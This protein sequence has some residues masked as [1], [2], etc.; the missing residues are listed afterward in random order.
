MLTAN[1]PEH[2]INSYIDNIRTLSENIIFICTKQKQASEVGFYY[3]VRYS[4]LFQRKT[5][6]RVVVSTEHKG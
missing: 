3:D 6:V 2:L 4:R 5:C 1:L